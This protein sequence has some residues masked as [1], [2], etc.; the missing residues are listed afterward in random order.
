MGRRSGQKGDWLRSHATYANVVTTLAL[1]LFV[2]GGA[3]MAL[4][5]KNSVDANDL[6]KNSVKARAIAKNAVRSSEIKDGAVRGAEVADGSLAYADLGSN[7]VVARLRSTASV[8]SAGGTEMN[9]VEVPLTGNTWT[10]PAH[11]ID[12]FF[13]ELRFTQSDQCQGGDLVIEFVV[14]GQVVYTDYADSGNAG[15]FTEPFLDA[16]PFL[17]EPGAPK[18]RTANLRIWDD[19]QN[20]TDFTVESLGINAVAVR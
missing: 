13:G 10:Q 5:G 2:A 7:S 8:S 3:A 12:V 4:P 11:E 6:K 1:I 14:D 19:C 15:T 9:P 20:G 16:R 18:E 17:F